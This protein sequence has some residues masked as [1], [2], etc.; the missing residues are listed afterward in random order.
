MNKVLGNYKLGYTRIP[1]SIS[2]KGQFG[3]VTKMPKPSNIK[4]LFPKNSNLMVH[5][6]F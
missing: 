3:A 1:L 4:T 2:Y 5:T 6:L